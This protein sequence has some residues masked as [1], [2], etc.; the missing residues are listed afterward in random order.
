MNLHEQ[1]WSN[2]NWCLFY[3]NNIFNNFSTSPRAWIHSSFVMR[4]DKITK[5]S[6]YMLLHFCWF[7]N[8]FVDYFLIL[9]IPLYS[10]DRV[11]KISLFICLILW[12]I[13]KVM[14][15]LRFRGN[16][17]SFIFVVTKIVT[18]YG[19]GEEEVSLTPLNCS[20]HPCKVLFFR[21]R[22]FS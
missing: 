18:K 5:S 12:K 11:D 13:E 15:F 20:M 14:V 21:P 16:P 9:N 17:F 6:K 1:K 22:A 8:F 2:K 19:V 3:I 7:S 10:W 4:V